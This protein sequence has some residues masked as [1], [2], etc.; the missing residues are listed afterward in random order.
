MFLRASSVSDLIPMSVLKRVENH[1]SWDY[2]LGRNIAMNLDDLYEST[3]TCLKNLGRIN[4][5]VTSADSDLRLILVPELWERLRPGSRKPLRRISSSLAEY[6][7]NSGRSLIMALS[8]NSRYELHEGSRLLRQRIEFAETLDIKA[9]L[10]WTRFS[11]SGAK[12]NRSY[13]PEYPVYEPAFAYRLVPVLAWRV[14]ES[15]SNGP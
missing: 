12:V 9:L 10:E 1:S 13:P 3:E 5:S 7:H 2:D 4:D 8:P 15:Q 11:I 14:L 6:I